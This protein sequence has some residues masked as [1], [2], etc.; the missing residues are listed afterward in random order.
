MI[1]S[2]WAGSGPGGLGIYTEVTG[3]PRAAQG[4][5]PPRRFFSQHRLNAC[6]PLGPEAHLRA[7]DLAYRADCPGAP[8]PTWSAHV[9]TEVRT[10]SLLEE[11]E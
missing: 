3:S 9:L 6:G 5:P 1:I 4:E 8:D 10:T 11:D 7:R 2:T